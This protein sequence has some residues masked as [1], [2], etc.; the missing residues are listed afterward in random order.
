MQ[1]QALPPDFEETRDTTAQDLES[2][3]DINLDAVHMLERCM[4][5]YHIAEVDYAEPDDRPATIRIRPAFIRTSKARNLVAWGFPVGADHWIDL[6]LDRIRDV[7][8]TGEVFQ[9]RW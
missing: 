1:R 8:D 3:P 9:P 6:R 4:A 5:E 7:R 2:V